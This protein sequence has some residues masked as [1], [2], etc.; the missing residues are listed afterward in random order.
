MA[1]RSIS[2]G[3]RSIAS[4]LGY[5]R[6]AGLHQTDRAAKCILNV[7]IYNMQML[8]GLGDVFSRVC[9]HSRYVAG[10]LKDRKDHTKSVVFGNG[11]R[12]VALGT[13]NYRL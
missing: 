8:W 4:G 12:V 6:I 2:R 13:T 5:I 1:V 9:M 3:S 11:F 7:Y 10:L